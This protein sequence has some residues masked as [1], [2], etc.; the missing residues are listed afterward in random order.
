MESVVTNYNTI[1]S[2]MQQMFG[3]TMVEDGRAG[4]QDDRRQ[5]SLPGQAQ[6][7][8]IKYFSRLRGGW[9]VIV[10]LSRVEGES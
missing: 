4:Y 5:F 1:I 6:R 9:G 10:I 2:V 7:C 8:I 3:D